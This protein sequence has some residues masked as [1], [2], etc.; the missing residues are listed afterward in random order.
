[1]S[2]F[3]QGFQSMSPAIG[4]LT[5]HLASH[6][7]R[8]GGNPILTWCISN[9]VAVSDPAGNL[10]LDKTKSFNRIDPVISL[11]MATRELCVDKEHSGISGGDDGIIF[12]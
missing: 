8:H 3:G 10:K 11:V 7:L 6:E 1:M 4:D 2:P 12:V 9:A 5:H